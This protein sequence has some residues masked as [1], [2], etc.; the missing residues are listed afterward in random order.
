MG[1]LAAAVGSFGLPLE[2]LG[3]LW[4][5]RR[6]WGPAGLP[7][8]LSLAAVAAAAATVASFSGEVHGWIGS[9]LP[10]LDAGAW[11]TWLWIGPARAALW[12]ARWLLFLAVA[13]AA[14]LVAFLLA[15]LVG[16]PFHDVLARRVEELETGRVIEIEGEGLGDT[17]REAL[18]SVLEE[19]RRLAFFASV[20]AL[21]FAVFWLVPGGQLLAPPALTLFAIFFLPLE[22]TSYTLDRRR[23]SFREKRSWLRDNAAAA[24]GYGGVAFA[25]CA[26]PLLNLLAMPVLVVSGTLLAVRHHRVG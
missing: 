14:V 21:L 8:V 17:L 9:Q 6:L 26:V 12:L 4:R 19:A 25:L 10:S 16:A 15:S 7:L 11:Y 1:A 13:A 24:L 22:Y 3:M 18:R 20:S 5:E 23:L 2:A